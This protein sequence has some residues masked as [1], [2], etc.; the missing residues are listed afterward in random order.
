MNE[1]VPSTVTSE[2]V[3]AMKARPAPNDVIVRLLAQNGLATTDVVVPGHGGD[4]ITVS[5]I[6]RAGRAEPDPGIHSIHGGG[7]GAATAL[8]G[9]LRGT[10]DVSVYAA[11]ARTTDLGGLPPAYVECGSAEVF[12]DEDVA[13]ASA[14]CTAGVHA[15]CTCGPVDSTGSR[16]SRARR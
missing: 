5:V 3:A 16:S 13:Y 2:M 9:A 15:G 6:A 14:L 8:L 4:A 12:R 7:M 10:E 1:Q 11:P